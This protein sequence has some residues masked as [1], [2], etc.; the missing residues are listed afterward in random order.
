M[1]RWPPAIFFGP[2]PVTVK[3]SQSTCSIVMYGMWYLVYEVL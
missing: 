1:K 3:V 2:E